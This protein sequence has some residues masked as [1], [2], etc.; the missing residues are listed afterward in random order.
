MEGSVTVRIV[1]PTARELQPVAADSPILLQRVTEGLDGE[2]SVHLS[3]VP[4]GH[5]IGAH[6]HSEPEVM[7]I[8]SGTATVGETVCPTGTLIVIPANERYSVDAGDEPL[9]FAVVRP[10]RAS[11]EF[12]P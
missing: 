7:V 8:L 2:P 12:A 11:F 5:H 6:S 4:A 9:T 1:V 10:R 3:Q